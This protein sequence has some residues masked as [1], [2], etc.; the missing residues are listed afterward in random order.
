MDVF[1]RAGAQV[2]L[3]FSELWAIMSLSFYHCSL[4]SGTLLIKTKSNVCLWV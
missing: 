1:F 2:S 4:Q 3:F